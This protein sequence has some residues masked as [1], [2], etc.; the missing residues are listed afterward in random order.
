M[1]MNSLSRSIVVGFLSLLAVQPACA[2]PSVTVDV[3]RRDFHYTEYAAD[4]SVLDR[5]TGALPGMGLH[6]RHHIGN[7][8]IAFN[9]AQYDG[10]L[11]YEGQTQAGT[12]HT[13]KTATT[14]QETGLSAQIAL[15]PQQ[16]LLTISYSA[17]T[18]KRDILP[19]GNVLG[20]SEF[21]RWSTI[22]LGY[23]FQ[24]HSGRHHFQLGAERLWH[25]N[26]EMEID[27]A[28]IAPATIPL[29][30]GVGWQGHLHY[31]FALDQHW[32]ISIQH[33][34]QQWSAERS[35]DVVLDSQWGP[36]SA[37]EPRSKTYNR[38]LRFSVNYNF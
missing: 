1:V 15:V 6:L 10:M 22:K 25:S 3:L 13:T 20:L 12:P 36:I 4:D 14:I 24:H 7:F 34:W 37:H 32:Q 19:E 5:E 38:N 31:A 16:H 23:Q 28:G 17:D 29:K 11:D 27:I 35:A 26:S 33:Q 2:E 8:E 18:W 9:T 30:N 21:Y